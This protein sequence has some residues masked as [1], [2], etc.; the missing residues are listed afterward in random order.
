MN[1]HGGC[2]S[3][4]PSSIPEAGVV[5][6]PGSSGSFCHRALSVLFLERAQCVRAPYSAASLHH[7][8]CA[9][10]ARQ[11]AACLFDQAL[12]AAQH[13]AHFFLWVSSES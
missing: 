5:R 12:A 13:P 1:T 4:V 6:R 2:V 11:G 3:Y 10:R 8:K 7:R 9:R